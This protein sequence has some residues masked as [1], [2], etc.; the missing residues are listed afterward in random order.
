TL[1][2]NPDT[3]TMR[4]YWSIAAKE[5]LHMWRDPTSLVIALLIPVI[6][7]ILFGFAIDFDVRHIKTMVIDFDHSRESRA[8]IQGLVNTQY[9]DVAAYGSGP[10]EAE[11]ALRSGAV[12]IAV[13]IPPDFARR[14]G[15][16]KDAVVRVLIDG[17]DNQVAT[18][19]RLAF[20]GIASQ[21]TNQEF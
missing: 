2:P 19:A 12:R 15:G 21:G 7:L 9:I 14:A 10:R 16:T 20:I 8:Y 1:D 4:G 11:D 5:L 6:Q 3:L 17:S 18:R 13:I